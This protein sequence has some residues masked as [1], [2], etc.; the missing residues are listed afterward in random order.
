M[1]IRHAKGGI[2]LITN[3]LVYSW[4]VTRRDNWDFSHSQ[5]YG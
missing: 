4:H 1:R 2:M 3:S 5:D